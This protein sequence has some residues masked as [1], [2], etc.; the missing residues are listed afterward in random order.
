MVQGE[1]TRRLGIDIG[2]TTAKIAVLDHRNNLVFADYVRHNARTAQTVKSILR[3]VA[4]RWDDRA[5][6]VQVTGSA[7]IGLAE[8]CALPFVQEVVASAEAA[9]RAFHGIRTLVDVGGED[10]KVVYFDDHLRPDIRMNGSCAGGTGAFIDQMASLLGIPIEKLNDLA[11]DFQHLH[12]IASRCGVFG[13]TDVQNLISRHVAL[14][15]IVASVFHAVSVQVINTL[16]RGFRMQPKVLLCGGP[17]AFIPVLRKVFAEAAGIALSD[18]VLPDR[19]ELLPAIGA[20]MCAGNEAPRLRADELIGRLSAGSHRVPILQDR[21]APLF[22]D[23]G[24]AESWMHKR[25]VGAPRIE[26]AALRGQNVFIGIDSGSTTSKMVLVD[27]D[28]RLALEFYRTNDGD[29]LEAVRDGLRYFR[30]R[31][32]A[33]GAEVR[34]CRTVVTGYGEDLIRTA[35]GLDHGVVETIAH[36]RA[37]REFCPEVSFVI[38]IGGQDMKA[39]FI[40][41]RTIERI[42]VNE[43]CSSGC[44]SFIQTFARTLGSTV[45]EFAKEACDA[46]APCN[47]GSRCTVFMNSKV[48]QFLREGAGV[49]DISAGLAYSVV[50]NSLNKV[51]KIRDMNVL[52]EH[53]VVQ[54]G[55]FQNPAVHRAFEKLTGKA[56]M[57]PDISGLMGAY[58]AA[59]LAR[60]TWQQAGEPE[61][62][63]SPLDGVETM[64]LCTRKSLTCKGCENQCV[65]SRLTFEHGDVFYT[66]N[67]CERVFGNVGDT[68]PPGFNFVAFKRE[69]LFDRPLEPAAGGRLTIGVPRVLN[70][71]ENFPFW[72]TLLVESGIKVE[73]S[74]PST[75]PVYEKGLGTVMSDSICFPAKLV[76]G[77]IVDLAERGVD[78][79]FYPIVVYESKSKGADNCFNCPIVT[80]YPDV[81]ANAINPENTY[82]IPLDHPPVNLNDLKLLRKTCRKYLAGLG[83]SRSTFER[84]FSRALQAQV[85]YHRQLQTRAREVA[86]AAEDSGRGLV[87]LS[88]RP[89]HADPLINHDVPEIIA[90]YGLDIITEDAL[91]DCHALEDLMVITQ[92]TYPNRMYSAARYCLDHDNVEMVQVNSFGC[93]PDAVA[94][95]EITDMLRTGGRHLTLIRVDEISS[96]G[97][98][99]LRLRTMIE[100]L[101]LRGTKTGRPVPRRDLP[102]FEAQHR[103]RTVI[104]PH[105]AEIYS[106][107]L[108]SAFAGVGLNMVSLPE[109][110][111]RSQELGLKYTNNEL[112]Y[113]G[114]LIVGDVIKALQ[115]GKYRREDTVVAMTQTG[116]QCRASNYFGLIKKGMIAAGFDDI[117]LISIATAGDNVQDQPGF[118]LDRK[119]LMKSA[120]LGMLFGDALSMM[121]QT[122]R[123]RESH[124][125]ETDRLLQKY[126]QEAKPHIRSGDSDRLLAVL[127][128]AVAEFNTV[129]V[130]DGVYP[131]V[132]IVGEIFVKYSSYANHH[133]VDWLTNAGIEIVVPPLSFFFIQELLNV[134]VD[135]SA[136][137]KRRDLT[138]LLTYYIEGR[139]NKTIDRVA[140]VLKGYVRNR[141]LHSIRDLAR[142]AE[143]RINLVNQYGEGWLITAEMMMFGESGIEQVVCL[144][145]FGCISNQVVA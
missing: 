29:H 137:I 86:Q 73:L 115:S 111:E 25:F 53:I 71:Y 5:F 118:T 78:R 57:C 128:D 79:I 122:T 83:I 15:D 143:R 59:L 42:E 132:G 81:I 10:S 51:L 3:R 65:V 37:A 50:R 87:R 16:A 28:G 142:H 35:F 129:D 80:G 113:P 120:L 48:K 124:P 94:I 13:K 114:I 47:L 116:G 131:R 17:F 23:A 34:V 123:V 7:G 21:L 30:D 91:D 126:I 103:R 127:R 39:M 76:H 95:D 105:F 101:K 66:G 117:P 18:I 45:E 130:H 107:L 141:P 93:G 139:L 62:R 1:D 108:P 135:M 138:W 33:V 68:V 69:L 82:D 54:G 121:R 8:R 97:S 6:A 110:D 75:V 24:E 109:S 100:A 61:A 85:E 11:V 60:E 77:H 136:G 63:F 56:V 9:S 96:P 104:V 140:S 144:Q 119:Q 98:I 106:E 43:A 31:L 55:T 26:P 84:A 41:G 32:A 38:D 44:G 134:R 58:G 145:P 125:G 133:V 4:R 92:W 27:S 46:T 20:A 49:P 52:G 64:A 88:G 70:M 67:R 72:C 99:R 102:P 74:S 89:Y 12:P 36:Y 112:C 14:S 22:K 2:S 40:A 90:S 19:P